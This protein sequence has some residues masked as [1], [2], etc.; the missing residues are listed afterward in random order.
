MYPRQYSSAP[1]ENNVVIIHDPVPEYPDHN[2]SIT[3]IISK[4][5]GKYPQEVIFK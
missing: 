4:Y 1:G 5:G 3:G 2:V